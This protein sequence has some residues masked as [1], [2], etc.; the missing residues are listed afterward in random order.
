MHHL[1]LKF[2]I[3]SFQ[4]FWKSKRKPNKHWGVRENYK[5]VESICRLC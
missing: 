2:I 4:T 3:R 1:L 5:T